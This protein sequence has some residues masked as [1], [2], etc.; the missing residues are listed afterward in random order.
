[1]NSNEDNNSFKRVDESHPLDIYIGIDNLSRQTFFLISEKEPTSMTSSQIISASVGKRK[2][3]KWGIS[4][5][6]LDNKYSDI[7]GCFCND[8]I[9]SSRLIRN[10]NSGA[11]FIVN[12]YIKWQLMLSRSKGG[13]LTHSVIKG[14]IGE[15][16]FLK[17][18]LIPK[19]GQ[20]IAVNSWIGPDKA[21]QDFVCNNT[22]YEVKSTDSGS[23]GINITSVEQL[24]MQINGELV[25]VY[26]DKTSS[27][28]NFKITLNK[29]Y[30]EVHDLL[31]DV[32]LKNKLSTI[33]LN[34]GYFPRPE[35]D[36]PAFKLT[37]VNRFLVDS[38]FPSIRRKNI[39]Q[40]IIN[41]KY[42][43]SISAINNHLI[44]D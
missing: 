12:R 19:Y 20:E 28:D 35:Y 17:E 44:K 16:H 2:D 29:I 25:I 32:N 6:L 34:L 33:L 26:L 9:E 3:A 15:I 5:T 27:A 39:P 40:A 11:D 18:Y 38:N 30:K 31:K 42:L 4:F 43:L 7:F 13:L 21:D 1:M 23:E 10:K 14:L 22:W 8:I 24:D 37:K 36:E 41:S